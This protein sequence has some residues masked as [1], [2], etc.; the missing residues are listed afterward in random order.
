MIGRAFYRS[1]A[2]VND[3]SS[4]RTISGEAGGYFGWCGTCYSS[5]PGTPGYCKQHGVLNHITNTTTDLEELENLE[6]F[7]SDPDTFSRPTINENWGYCSEGCSKHDH[8]QGYSE[9]SEY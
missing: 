4:D 3:V 6:A 8:N 9:V 5:K 1:V 7:V 2:Q